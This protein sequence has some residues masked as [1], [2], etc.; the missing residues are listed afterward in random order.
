MKIST[1]HLFLLNCLFRVQFAIAHLS[2]GK[3]L[4][5]FANA[6]NKIRVAIFRKYNNTFFYFKFEFFADESNYTSMEKSNIC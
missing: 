5:N 2:R 6:K 3:A 1:I 4:E